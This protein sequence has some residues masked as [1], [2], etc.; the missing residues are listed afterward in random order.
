MRF[1]MGICHSMPFLW[2]QSGAKALNARSVIQGT[3]AFMSSLCKNEIVFKS[4]I[5]C[6]ISAH[7]MIDLFLT[8]KITKNLKRDIFHDIYKQ[9]NHSGEE[10]SL[11]MCYFFIYYVLNCFKSEYQ[12][13]NK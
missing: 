11:K 4:R 2:L 12:K 8:R 10:V 6:H 3:R 9:V 7:H 5:S 1:G 13:V